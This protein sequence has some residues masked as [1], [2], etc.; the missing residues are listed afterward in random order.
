MVAAAAT[1]AG[2]MLVSLGGSGGSAS[3]AQGRKGEM[4]TSVASSV[5]W[6]VYALVQP[7]QC[8]DTGLSVNV[9]TGLYLSSASVRS[10]LCCSKR[11]GRER[12]G[13][14][15]DAGCTTAMLDAQL[16]CWMDAQLQYCDL[17]MISN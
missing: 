2:V 9:V 11:S 7:A 16:Q 13:G 1:A 8:R 14:M 17:L 4:A 10:R 6:L 5:L 3:L 12:R 15:L